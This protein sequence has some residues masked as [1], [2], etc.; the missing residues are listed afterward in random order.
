MF[1]AGGCAPFIDIDMGFQYFH[2]VKLRCY[3]RTSDSYRQLLNNN[4]VKNVFLSFSAN[5]YLDP[6]IDF[7]DLRG[8]IDF[9]SD[10]G[11]A[12]LEGIL[13]TVKMAQ[14]NGKRVFI[15]EDLPD[16]S[17]TS[18]TSCLA[19]RNNLE[20]SIE[21]LNLQSIDSRYSRILDELKSY[22]VEVIHTKHLLSHFPYTSKGDL[23]YRDGTHLSKSG[24]YYFGDNLS[25]KD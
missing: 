15:I 12:V 4:S 14:T 23:M 18:F 21:C 17:F 24:S 3:E 13:R 9:N 22:G 16:V 11:K 25:L 5:G 10:R 19:K 2:G 7:N 20:N 6:K 1:G 8:E